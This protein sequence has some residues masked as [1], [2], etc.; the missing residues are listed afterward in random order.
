[1]TVGER[2]GL[3]GGFDSHGRQEFSGSDETARWLFGLVL[4]TEEEERE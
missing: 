3:G 4:G 2:N 1:M